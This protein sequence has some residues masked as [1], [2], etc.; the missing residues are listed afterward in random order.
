MIR[1][2]PRSTLFPYTTL[3]RSKT[4]ARPALSEDA[5]GAC[6]SSWRC[7]R[8]DPPQSQNQRRRGRHWPRRSHRRPCRRHAVVALNDGT[9]QVG[10]LYIAPS[11]RPRRCA[12][13]PFS[14]TSNDHTGA[15]LATNPF[16]LAD[17][18]AIVRERG[19]LTTDPTPEI[20]AWCGHAEIGRAH[21]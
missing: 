5:R 12:T 1:R 20:D 3:F 8:K 9:P 11:Y 6:Q 21:V 2:P 10:A 14:M 7:R 15:T 16:T 13:M 17:V 18:L 19:W 4:K